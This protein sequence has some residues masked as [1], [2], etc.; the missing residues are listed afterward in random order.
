[1]EYSLEVV[2]AYM[3]HIQDCADVAVREMLRAFSL[4]EGMADVGT[5]TAEDFLDDGTPIRLAV[6]ID[7]STGTAVFDFEGTGL[8]IFGNL[9]APPAVTTS[10]IIYCLRCLLPDIDIPL[11]QVCIMH[12]CAAS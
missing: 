7:R 3:Q 5:A 6:T 11:N 9:N 2:C 1:L 12:V 8:E 10:A 4:R